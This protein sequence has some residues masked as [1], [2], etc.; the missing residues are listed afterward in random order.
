MIISM[1]GYGNHECENDKISFSMELKSVNS[2]YFESSIKLPNLFSNEEEKIVEILRKELIRGR[3]NL[4]F[5]Y[6][7][8][9]CNS[10]EY[11]LN[12]SKLNDCIQVLNDI[13]KSADINSPILLSDILTFQDIIFIDKKNKD[14]SAVKLLYSGLKKLIEDH[15]LFRLKEGKNIEKDILRKLSNI[16]KN[17]N[18]ISMLWKGQKGQYFKKYKK[19]ISNIIDKY[20]LNNDRLF[21]EVA[22]IL[23][24]RDI[25][26]EIVRL[27]SHIKSFISDIKKH[28]ILGKRLTFLIQE[29]LRESN[30]IG[31]KSENIKISKAVIDIK[32]DL[33]KIKEQVQNIL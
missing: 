25:N 19:R 30:T 24:K 6:K 28:R 27:E 29:L 26:E 8:K 31:S 14:K 11:S 16:S 12:T 2:R 21:Q 4:N 23:D 10:S 13:R 18:K 3:V 20:S 1:T 9:N 22:I 5:S 15:Q 7:I 32:T 33:E 17:I